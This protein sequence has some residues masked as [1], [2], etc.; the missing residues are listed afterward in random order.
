MDLIWMV[1]YMNKNV[2]YMRRLVE[3]IKLIIIAMVTLLGVSC[4]DE[5]GDMNTV[6]DGTVRLALMTR[7]PDGSSDAG[8]NIQLK[9]LTAYR[10]EDGTLREVLNFSLP[11]GE[12]MT[13]LSPRQM[14]GMLYLLANGGE[15]L[16]G[17]NPV[18]DVTTLEEFLSLP[19]GEKGLTSEAFVMG[20]QVDLK[21]AGHG[22]ALNMELRRSVA[23]VDLMMP[24]E[25]VEV[26]SVTMRGIPAD[27]LLFPSDG[28]PVGTPG[29]TMTWT[30]QLTDEPLPEGGG[31]L[32]YLPVAPLEAPVEIEALLLVNGNRHWVRTQI[33]ALKSNTVYTLRVLG[34]GAQAFLDVV[35][36]DWIETDPVTPGVSQKVYVDASGSV[37]PEGARLSLHADTVFVPFQNNVIRL[38]IAGTSG[39]QASI[40]GYVDGVRVE[41]DTEADQRQ[42][43][44]ERIAMAEI[45]SVKCIPGEKRGFIHLNFSADEVQEGRI[46]VAFDRN[47]LQVTEGS[48]SFG[49]DGICD[50]GTYADGTLAHLELDGDYELRLRLPEGED[51]WAKLFPGE[52]DSEFVLE[53][54][55]K[56]NDPLADGRAQQVELVIYGSDGSELDSYVVKRRN[57]GL[58]VVCVNGTWW[59]KYNLRGNV[60]SF[61]D[62]VTIA[63]DPVSADQLGEY[64][65]TCSNERFLELLGDQYQGGNLQGLKLQSGDNGFW[66]EGFSASA[67]D[68]GAMDASAMAP[69]GYEI[70]D[71][72]D[73]RFFAW[74]N[75]CAL[76]YGSNAFNNGLGQ[77]LSYTITERILT[78][79]GKEYGPV[80]VYDFYHEADGSHWVMASLGHQWDASE[81]SVSRMVALFATSGRK[82]MTW[83]IEGYPANSSGG[84]RSWIKYAANN[85]SKTRTIRCIK[86]PVRYMYE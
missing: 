25:G 84:R 68:F 23:R 22:E 64:L 33:P 51:P 41:L 1:Y 65:L 19:L 62:Q 42:K 8:E 60:R 55:W 16:A 43:G 81:G 24:V 50:L 9:E 67:Q 78:V 31:V 61:E 49:A 32:R 28:V 57:W 73:F 56:P 2:R 29:E 37:L 5:A 80:N 39:L 35:A 30:R 27:G 48:V 71:Y 21:D 85:S 10:F 82:G 70:P 26:V 53:G 45:E 86:T 15:T 83:G 58:P 3:E 77:R 40:D 72:D 38:A 20:G 63:D 76:G 75:D 6:P 12:G 44:M 34:M 18:E 46:V 13:S 17:R 4:T 47:P 66:Y 59:C 69:A 11:D 54:G 79:N 74:G 7:T 14:R 52:T 36:S